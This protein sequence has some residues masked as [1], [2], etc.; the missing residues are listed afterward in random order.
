M[1]K[2]MSV[3]IMPLLAT[4]LLTTPLLALLTVLAAQPIPARTGV[5]GA[6]GE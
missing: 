4:P 5:P 3:L 6:V 2:F 1:R